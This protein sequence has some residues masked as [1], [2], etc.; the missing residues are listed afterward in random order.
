MRILF[1][2]AWFPYPPDNGSKLRILSLLKGLSEY[3]DITL[4]SFSDTDDVHPYLP[5]LEEYCRCLKVARWKS[6]NPKSLR[7]RLGFLN[8][9]PRSIVDTFSPPMQ[10]LIED[11]LVRNSYDVI[12]ASEFTMA[13]YHPSF[14]GVPAL[15]EDLQLGLLYSQFANA[16]S[17]YR[18]IRHG[19]TWLKTSRYIADMLKDFRMCTVN[20]EPERQILSLAVPDY[21]HVEV[22]TNCVDM[23][24]YRGVESEPEPNTLIYPGALTYFANYDAMDFF[25]NQIH[26]RIRCEIPEVAL[27]ITGR[28][29]GVPVHGLPLDE[30]VTLTGNV[31]DVR[32]LIAG[33]AVMVVPLRLGQGQRLKILESLALRTPVVATSKGAEGLA[34]QHDKHLLIAD[35]PE[36]FAEAVIRL[37]KEPALHQRLADNAYQLICEKYDWAVAMPHFLDLVE[38]IGGK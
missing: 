34:V 5:S 11:E 7:A 23:A 8:Q 1:L 38:R 10:E 6:F 13:S 12:I 4:L 36:A 2:S 9:V 26:P 27:R 31:E 18:K 25:L 3:H 15:L 19:L 29:E 14:R 16:K 35:T 21:Q 33:S 20:S 17:V 30:S 24:R 32:P 22:I 37:L 28:Y